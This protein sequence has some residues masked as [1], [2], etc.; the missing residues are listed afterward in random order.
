MAINHWLER[1]AVALSLA[2]LHHGLS[3]LASNSIP[4]GNKTVMATADD[5]YHHL[6]SIPSPDSDRA[7]EGVVRG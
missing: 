6:N 7:R 4:A 5:F 3:C 1:R 2:V